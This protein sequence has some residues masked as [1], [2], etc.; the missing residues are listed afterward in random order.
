M[1][2]QSG[3]L[4]RKGRYYLNIRVPN[5]LRSLY[6]R[7][8]IIRKALGT[9][10][11]REAVSRVRFEAFKYDAEFAAKRLQIADAKPIRL[12]DRV[13][14]DREAHQMV[15]RWLIERERLSEQWWENEGQK[16]EQ[17][18]RQEAVK[19]LKIDAVVYAGGSENYQPSDGSFELD[20]FLQA[21]GIDCPKESPAYQKLRP[22][23]RKAS[24]EN[25]LRD[26]DRAGRGEA[27]HHS[28]LFREVFAHTEPQA[29]SLQVTVADMVDRFL[30][31]LTDARR[32]QGTLRT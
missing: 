18:E 11:R 16:L 31:W 12:N 22:L 20:T 10:D 26:I 6:G 24:L 8:D 28:P 4:C 7:R 15:A 30:K 9:S 5:E 14:S 2:H 13:L 25:V 32:T 17:D 29:V 21:E 23:F 3:L 19:G 27:G 1:P